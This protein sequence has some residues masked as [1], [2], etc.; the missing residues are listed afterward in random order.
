MK[1]LFGRVLLRIPQTHEAPRL[2][3]KLWD[4]S[5]NGPFPSDRSPSA[6]LQPW[7]SVIIDIGCTSG[8]ESDFMH[9]MGTWGVDS[10][11]LTR[12][13]TRSSRSESASS[14]RHLS[15]ACVP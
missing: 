3:S 4:A 5:L 9:G 8:N 15:P 6:G 1:T 14:Q 7:K 10:D 13:R 11:G 12:H 2:C